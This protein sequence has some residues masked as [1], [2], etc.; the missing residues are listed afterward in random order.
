MKKKAG[1]K[2]VVWIYVLLALATVV[3]YEPVRHNGFVYDDEQYISINPDVQ[4][5]ITKES[6]VW[7]LTSSYAANWHPLTWL[8]HMLDC[9]FF[10]LNPFWHHMTNLLFHV[11]NSLL[12]FGVLKKMTGAV[13]RSGFV[14]AVFALHPVHVESVAWIAE[15]KDVLS[16]FFWMLT[17]AAYIRYVERPAIGR[18]VLV[19]LVFGLGLMAKPMLVTLPFVLLLL[20]YW[21]LNRIQRKYERNTGTSIRRL[22]VEKIPL[23][24]LVG[25]SSAITY[26]AQRSGG[27][28]VTVENVPLAYRVFN[29][30]VS[31]IRYF[32]KMIYPERLAALYPHPGNSLAMWQPIACFAVLSLVSL[33]VIYFGRRQRYLAVG[34]FWYIGTL[35]PVIGLVQVGSQ[36]IA[37]RYTYIPSIGIFILL[38]WGV[39]ELSLKWR[40][41]KTICRIIAGVLLVL[42]LVLTRIQVRHWRDNLT[43]YGHALAVIKNNYPMY[44]NYGYELEKTGRVEDAILSYKKA[45]RIAPD[46]FNAHSNLGA[47]LCKQGKFSEALK[48]FQR[49]VQ[50][51][52]NL[53][54]TYNNLGALFARQRKFDEAITYYQQALQINGNYA[55]THYNLATAFQAQK[56]FDEAIKHFKD[57]LRIEPDHL[58]AM[59]NLGYLLLRKGKFDEA[60]P[61][62]TEALQIRPD[63]ARAQYDVGRAHA[64]KGAPHEAIKYFKETI[65][66]DPNYAPAHYNLAKILSNDGKVSEAIW[67]FREAL[68]LKPDWIIVMNDLAWFLAT[69]KSDELRDTTEAIRLGERVCE[70]TK[71]KNP[72]MLDT[73]AAAYAADG[74]FPEAVTTAQKALGLA[75]S[76]G[77]AKLADQIQERLLL[78]KSSQPYV[79][80]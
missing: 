15:R 51:K 20:D 31:Y 42:L 60:I 37:D 32:G 26:V 27:A 48:H 5:G 43:L 12:L 50:I 46:H 76:A 9:Q 19:F 71:Y 28:V 25:V 52:P 53:A 62:L 40:H 6:V 79:A 24:F 47:L 7:A 67:H 77:E 11:V 35:V 64:G 54:K 34:W 30:L 29:A 45:V 68:R 55:T 63:L 2:Y 16:G 4:G 65:R 57:A 41:S 59:V 78:Y 33:A 8:S 66:L 23:L 80:P 75:K 36:A 44:Y 74:R 13:W 22:I 1:K 21:P 39:T 18:Y 61:Y 56:K 70:L 10:G 38:A 69:S 17:I 49:A 14:A 73:L 58:N 3:A 72:T